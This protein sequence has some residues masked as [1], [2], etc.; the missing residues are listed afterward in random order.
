MN[1]ELSRRRRSVA[2]IAPQVVG[3]DFGNIERHAGTR[4]LVAERHDGDRGRLGHP[5][6]IDDEVSRGRRRE[7]QSGEYQ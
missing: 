4:A 3:D 1:P 2:E 7:Q 5:F 6:H